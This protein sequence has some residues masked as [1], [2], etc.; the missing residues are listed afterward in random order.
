MDYRARA[1]AGAV[2]LKSWSRSRG[3]GQNG[4]APQHCYQWCAA[5]L[6]CNNV[7]YCNNFILERGGK[8]YP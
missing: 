7:Q 4:M 8:P 2:N 6:L 3:G 1:G 5:E